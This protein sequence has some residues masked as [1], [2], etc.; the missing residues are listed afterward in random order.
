MLWAYRQTCPARRRDLHERAVESG[1]V[2]HCQT[3]PELPGFC[4]YCCKALRRNV[5]E[6]IC[7]QCKWSALSGS[8]GQEAGFDVGHAIGVTPKRSALSP[9]LPFARLTSRIPPLSMISRMLNPLFTWDSIHPDSLKTCS[10][11]SRRPKRHPRPGPPAA[12]PTRDVRRREE[13]QE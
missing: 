9:S 8:T 4:Q 12:F 3:Q 11:F 5:L 6:L 7:I 13:E 2:R 1:L 10:A